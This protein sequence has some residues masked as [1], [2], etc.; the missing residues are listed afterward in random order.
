MLSSLMFNFLKK[1]QETNTKYFHVAVDTKGV[2]EWSEKNKAD[3]EDGYKKAFFR[4]KEIMELQ[5][6]QKIPILSFLILP[7]EQQD[8]QELLHQFKKLIDDQNFWKFLVENKIRVNLFG[9]WYDLPSDI[10]GLLKNLVGCTKDYDNFFV[11]FCLNYDGKEE[12]VNACKLIARQ[13]ESGKLSYQNITQET[14]KENI[15]TSY[16]IQPNVMIKNSDNQM[17]SF[18]LWDCVG[19]KRIFTHK[20]FP[21]LSKSDV[22]NILDE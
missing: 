10:L 9:K 13:V 22:E 2:K 8:N 4:V 12:I 17:D 7:L 15:Y 1:K 6:E 11:N 16:F 21:D 19:A 20:Y 5:I 3:L 14:I 18:F